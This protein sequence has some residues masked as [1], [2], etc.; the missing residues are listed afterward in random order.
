[1]KN[2]SGKVAVITGGA[3][4]IGRALAKRCAAEGMRLVLADVEDK[5]LHQTADELQAAGAQVLVVKTDVSKVSQVEAL[6]EKAFA[7]SGEVTLLFNNAG[8]SSGGKSA[9]E[10]SLVEWEWV[11]GVNLWGVIYGIRAFLPKMLEQEH[12]GYIVNTA[13][14]AGLVSY[15]GSAVY[16][17]SK[18]GVVTLSE[19]LYQELAQRHPKVLVSV[20]CPGLVNTRIMEAARNRP[21]ELQDRE[22]NAKN[23]SSSARVCTFP[24]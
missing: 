24:S 10:S 8:V 18:H 6:A 16:N 2:F 12:G 4:G 21:L 5:G 11:L 22:H 9:W 3:S 19:T 15:P 7:I 14:L 13:S 1:M 23:S 17:V 20:L